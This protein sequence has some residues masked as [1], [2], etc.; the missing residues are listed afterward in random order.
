MEGPKPIIPLR[1]RYAS[2]EMKEIFPPLKDYDYRHE[3]SH[4]MR[5]IFSDEAKYLG[6]R[7]SWVALTEAQ[8]E[9]GLNITT[10]QLTAIRSQEKVIDFKAAQEYERKTKHDVQSYLLEFRDR[11]N[12]VMPGAGNV[13][14][15][16]ATSCE[17]TDPEELTSMYKGLKL[18]AE[19][20]REVRRT[21]GNLLDPAIEEVDYRAEQLRGRGAKGTTGTQA[22]YLELFDGNHDKVKELDNILAKKLGFKESYTIMGQTYP[23]IV[24]YQVLSSILVLG[25]TLSLMRNWIHPAALV[26]DLDENFQELHNKSIQAAYMA[27]GQWWERSLDD[28]SERRIIISEAFYNADYLLDTFIQFGLGNPMP[29]TKRNVSMG[30]NERKALEDIIIPKIASA[31]DKM[32]SF[33]QKY[34]DD[35][36]IA[37]THGQ[38]AQPTTYGKRIDLWAYNFVLALKDFE[39]LQKRAAYQPTMGLLINTKLN[40]VA[41]AASKMALDIRL[42]QHDLEVNEPF[43]KSQTGSTAMPYKKNPMSCERINGL[44]RNKIGA[45]NA[46]KL[47][48]YDL[49]NTDAI[50]EIVL[51]VLSGDNEKQTGFTVHTQ[52]AR[53]NLMKFMP[54]F[55]SEPFLVLGTNQGGDNRDI[56]EKIRESAMEARASIDNGRGNNMLELMA[57][58]GFPVDLSKKAELI[59]PDTRVGRSREQVDDF[60]KIEIEPIIE[61][62]AKVLGKE[63]NVQI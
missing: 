63:G 17:I 23:R 57:A 24:D 31:I 6:W 50:L 4:E 12:S 34:R 51:K 22:S 21:M 7:R 62:Y 59:D 56:H 38:F 36:C 29:E 53:A 20:A 11:V 27:S 33:A 19:K 52:T 8:Q 45:S 48:D 46:V 2:K 58:N 14:H 13:L 55:A 37:Y 10:Q 9:L 25:E 18:L 28:S 47:R 61:K 54:F 5:T 43:G 60:G 1:G 44:S 35:V 3:C 26:P 39:N 32:H 49:L 42:S 16:G 15:N 30:T 40:Q 41:V